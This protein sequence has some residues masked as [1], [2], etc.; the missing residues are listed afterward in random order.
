[1]AT[2]T[3]IRNLVNLGSNAVLG[4]GT[5]GAKPFLEK[6]AALWLLP[7]GFALNGDVALDEAYVLQLQAE[8]NLVIL[9]GIRGFTD[10]SQDNSTEELEDGTIS[11][12]K[13]GK[14]GF[15]ANF[16]NGF[17]FNAALA[18]VSGFGSYDILFIDRMG[19]VLGTES[20]SGSLKGFTTG[21]IQQNKITWATDTTIQR[22]GI[23]W[24]FLE[25]A[26]LDTNYFLI[27]QLE[28]N[29][30]PKSME[31]INEVRLDMTV[32][33]D[34]ATTI[35][36]KAV[37]KQDGKAFI[38]ALLADFLVKKN[39]ATI[40]PTGVVESPNGIYTFTVAALATNDDLTVGL[41]NS[42]DSVE[43]ITLDSTLF[44]S[45]SSFATVI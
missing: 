17:M 36:V 32:P 19:N 14:Y 41:Y 23:K 20:N 45:N 35:V 13:L 9:N 39:G 11:V 16:I 40:T 5:K 8:G 37:T 10:E 34:L 1:M 33:A 27:K 12:T 38:G 31:G 30:N 44:K 22:E 6:V 21:M 18:A 28:L 29:F 25:R 42:V 2:I 7:A 3:N 4:T 26:E 24:Q 15:A 43:V